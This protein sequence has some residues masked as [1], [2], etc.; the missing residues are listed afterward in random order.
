MKIVEGRRILRGTVNKIKTC[1]LEREKRDTA[2]EMNQN[3]SKMIGSPQ[4]L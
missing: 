3:P 1:C 4:G 2:D